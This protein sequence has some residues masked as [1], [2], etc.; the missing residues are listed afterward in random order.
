MKTNFDEVLSKVTEFLKTEA[1]TE[2]VVGKEFKLGEFTCVPVIRV[3]LGFGY[4][5][6]EGGDEKHAHGEG[7]GAGAGIGIEPLGFLATHGKEISF[8]P[9]RTSHGLSA[10][11]EKIP[12]VLEKFLAGKE[13]PEMAKSN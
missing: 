13:K 2:T 6:G 12:D 11:I 7:S 3:G 10:A 9:S 5:A 4:G 8:V 1:R